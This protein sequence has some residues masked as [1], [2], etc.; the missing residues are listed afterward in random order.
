MRDNNQHGKPLGEFRGD[1][2]EKRFHE[3]GI[4]YMRPDDNSDRFFVWS[5]DNT[6]KYTFFAGSGLIL[7]PMPERGVENMIS[8]AAGSK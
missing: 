6:R 5:N 8:L 3:E 1:Y 7:G 4:R 2:A